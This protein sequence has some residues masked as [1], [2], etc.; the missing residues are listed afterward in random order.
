MADRPRPVDR[1]WLKQVERSFGEY[2][3]V[4][5]TA[6]GERGIVCRM[7]IEKESLNL[8]RRY[9]TEKTSAIKTAL[10]TLPEEPP[11]PFFVLQ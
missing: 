6:T 5:M 9:F 1:E 3:L 8:L 7:E 2:Q 11:N 10:S 4:P